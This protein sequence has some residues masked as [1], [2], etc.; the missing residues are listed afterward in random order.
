MQH[1][2]HI[3]SASQAVSKASTV[4]E[5]INNI[6]KAIKRKV[7]PIKAYIVSCDENAVTG[8]HTAV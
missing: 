6:H 3:L 7:Q 2:C 4:Y 1:N 8:P 5:L